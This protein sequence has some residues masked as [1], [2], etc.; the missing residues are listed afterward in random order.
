M[1]TSAE[2]TRCEFLEESLRNNPHDTFARYALALELAKSAPTE[3]WTHFEYLLTR[4]PEDSAT[5]QQAGTFLLNQNRREEAR[6]V[7]AQGVE[8]AQRQGNKHAQSALQA[9][10]D[11]LADE[12]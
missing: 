5:Y 10:L 4:H 2:K 9:A 6:R 12:M 1:S 3:A 8:V 7:L 11:E